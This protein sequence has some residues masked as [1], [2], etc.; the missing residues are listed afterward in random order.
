MSDEALTRFDELV[1]LI[2]QEKANIADLI[3]DAIVKGQFTEAQRMMTKVKRMEEVSNQV[4]RLREMWERLDE[5]WNSAP[6]KRKQS[7]FVAEKL[8]DEEYTPEMSVA[9]GLFGGHRRTQR[10]TRQPVN[11]TPERAY[12]VPILEALEQLGGSGSPKEVRRIVYEKM[13]DHFTEDDLAILPSTKDI[14]W[15]NTLMW[16]R[17]NMIKDGLLKDDS[18]IGIWEISDAGRAYLEQLRQQGREGEEK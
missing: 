2:Q 1:N 12:R 17:Y 9:D 15:A 7:E 11:K 14:R 18:P 6:L 13:K 5:A 8:F 3:K 16:E 10:R 4:Q